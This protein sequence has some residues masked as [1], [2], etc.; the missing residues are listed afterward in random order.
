[1][2]GGKDVV[3]IGAFLMALP[4]AAVRPTPEEPRPVV[5]IARGATLM[6]ELEGKRQQHK[7]GGQTIISLEKVGGGGGMHRDG[8]QGKDL[9]APRLSPS[10]I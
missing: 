10:M 2:W 3:M 4:T 1:M 8:H 9:F 7:Q 6:M 5:L